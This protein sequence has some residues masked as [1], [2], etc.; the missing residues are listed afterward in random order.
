MFAFHK[1][2][3]WFYNGNDTA[4]DIWAA[5]HFTSFSLIIIIFFQRSIFIY[6]YFILFLFIFTLQYCIG[7]AIHQH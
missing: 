2:I 5:S 6:F 3:L 1:E 7:F 4:Y